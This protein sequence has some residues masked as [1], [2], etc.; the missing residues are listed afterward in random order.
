[1]VTGATDLANTDANDGLGHPRTPLETDQAR[2]A[3][4]QAWSTAVDTCGRSRTGY[5]SDEFGRFLTGPGIRRS[6]GRTGIRHGNPTAESFFS[7]LKNEWPHR[8]VFTTR[9]KARRQVIRYIEGF[10]NHRRIHTALGYRPPFEVLN[11]SPSTPTAAWVR[12]KTAVR[13]HRGPSPTPSHIMAISANETRRLFAPL[14]RPPNNEDHILCWS[15]WRRRPHTGTRHS[16]YQRQLVKIDECGWNTNREAIRE[17][18]E[19]KVVASQAN[20][21][22]GLLSHYVDGNSAIAERESRTGGWK[23][24]TEGLSRACASP[25][26]I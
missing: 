21:T 25:P 4:E 18:W 14:I 24:F 3:A 9:A 7:A 5:T 26:R 1:M 17:Y 8:F 20:I 16:H 23:G 22:C 10:Y 19:R 12:R 2:E 15:W 6:V 11:E 13:N